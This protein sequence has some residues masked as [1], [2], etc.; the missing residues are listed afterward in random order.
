[1]KQLD[2]DALV[3]DL[4]ETYGIYDYKQL[5]LLKVAVFAYGLSDDSRIKRRFSQQKV[6]LDTLI[7]ASLYDQFNVL[8][9]AF[10][11]GKGDQPLSLTDTL[12]DRPTQSTRKE[13][14]FQSRE[15]F[16]RARQQLLE[17]LRKEDEERG[18]TI[19]ESVCA[20]DPVN[21]GD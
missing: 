2:E 16:N 13:H 5:P 11:N 9:Y 17:E 8:L 4:A 21:E 12:M 14:V 6:D 20:S 18:D 19:R 1:M 10:S 3:C 7:L 15:D